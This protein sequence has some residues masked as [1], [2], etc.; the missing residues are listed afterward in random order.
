MLSDAQVIMRDRQAFLTLAWKGDNNIRAYDD[1]GQL[2]SQWN[3]R[4]RTASDAETSMLAHI[5]R[6][7]Y[8][9][10]PFEKGE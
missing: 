5:S 3:I 9:L 1:L 6:G 2:V 4:Y 8:P 10:V 7:D